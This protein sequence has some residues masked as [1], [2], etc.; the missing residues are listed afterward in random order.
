M[1]AKITDTQRQELETELG[2][3]FAQLVIERANEQGKELETQN[4][5][6]KSSPDGFTSETLIILGA[7]KSFQD[8]KLEANKISDEYRKT[9]KD[10][11]N[12]VEQLIQGYGDL[13]DANKRNGEQVTTLTKTIAELTRRRPAASK[14][15][16]TTIEDDN[17][18]A[19]FLADKNKGD[20]KPIIP[21]L[22][23]MKT[24]PNG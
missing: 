16:E 6:F 12:Q 11:A 5:A 13:K 3:E 21:I 9:V 24:M 4:I 7:I 19:N 10:L 23:Q 1:N 22:T 8:E 15:E 14:S 20:D 18:A 2:K 17:K